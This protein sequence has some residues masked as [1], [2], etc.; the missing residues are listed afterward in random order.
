MLSHLT[1]DEAKAAFKA[2]L[3]AQ[4]PEQT[5]LPV[6]VLVGWITNGPV[7]YAVT[8]GGTTNHNNNPI[9]AELHRLGYPTPPLVHVSY[10]T[11]TTFHHYVPGS[12]NY[13]CWTN[14]MANTNGRTTQ[15]WEL[16]KHPSGWPAQPPLVKWN[17]NCLMWGMQGLTALSPCWQGEAAPGW[18]PFTAL[19]R[20]HGYAVGHGRGRNGLL[21]NMAGTKVWFLTKE[22]VA[23]EATVEREA[24]RTMDQSGRDYTIV[25]FKKDLPE[26]IEPIRVIT[27]ATKVTKYP[28]A[29]NAPEITFK[30]EQT[31]NVSAEISGFTV[32]TMKGGDS[33]SPNMIPMPG[34]LVFYGGRTT[35][36]PSHE[37]QADMD[38][39]CR[40]SGLD[41]AKYQLQWVDLSSFP[42]Y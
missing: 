37:M 19:T 35:S 3:A 18:V 20:R 25:L 4:Y 21:N 27:Y 14:L 38:E 10:F 32:P 39:L 7:V 6:N 24:V 36:P 33:G 42:S 29:L 16:R 13:V 12:L 23:I 40:L 34:E 31:G 11:N 30:T 9:F 41:P 17:T 15:I 1:N 26:S 8:R 2:R 28:V 22:N 5:L